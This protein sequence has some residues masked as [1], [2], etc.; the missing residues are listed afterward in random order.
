MIIV[1]SITSPQVISALQHNELII[2]L[3][4]T[5]YGILATAQ[6]QQA[7]DKLY[8]VRHRSLNKPCI[9]LID[10]LEFIPNLTTDQRQTYSKLNSERPTTIIAK[11]PDNF[12][13]HAPRNNHTLAFRVV[14]GKLATLI[15]NVGPI[16]APSANPEGLPP[17]KNI[18]QAIDYFGEQISVYVDGG[19]ITQDNPSRI[20]SLADNNFKIIRD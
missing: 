17:A 13:P 9:V 3:T 6:N 1:K 2:A 8:R 7:I 19:Q 18:N 12:L 16:L 11:V 15:K 10:H 20:V 14:Y 4:D 5:I